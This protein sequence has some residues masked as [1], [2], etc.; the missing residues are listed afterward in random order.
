MDR[1]SEF[2]C[3]EFESLRDAKPVSPELDGYYDM[4][5][6]SQYFDYRE[7]E[8]SLAGIYCDEFTYADY[9]IDKKLNIKYDKNTFKD[10]YKYWCMFYGIDEKDGNDTLCMIVSNFYKKLCKD[11]GM[12]KPFTYDYDIG[13]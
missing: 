11:V 13:R 10:R 12:S 9:L 6:I 2:N 1:Y 8:C 4:I 5:L 7:Y 3:E